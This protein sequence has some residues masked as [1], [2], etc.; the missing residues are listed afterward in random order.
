MFCGSI[1]S[2][3]SRTGIADCIDSSFQLLITKTTE[4]QICFVGILC[5]F[6]KCAFLKPGIWF[7]LIGRESFHWHWLFTVSTSTFELIPHAPFT[8][9][10]EKCAHLEEFS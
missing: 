7:E 5:C 9:S 6:S 10:G 2:K 4:E 3:R 8:M 1:F